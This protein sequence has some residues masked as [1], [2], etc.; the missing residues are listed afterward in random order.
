MKNLTWTC[1]ICGDERPDDKI[2][3]F[4]KSLEIPGVEAKQNVR[5][6]NDRQECIDGAQTF[7]FSKR[8]ER[9][10]D[11]D[12]PDVMTNGEAYGPAMKIT[13]KAEAKVYLQAL[14]DR[15]VR[16][17]DHDPT[18]AEM[19]VKTNLGY[20]SGYYDDETMIRVQNLFDCEHPVFGKAERG[21]PTPAE[22]FQM[23]VDL[24][25]KEEDEQPSKLG[26][27]YYCIREWLA[28]HWPKSLGGSG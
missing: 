10:L 2:S 9:G 26:K 24:A 15:H 17:T 4:S 8:G 21:L 20:Y 18:E 19:I 7:S 11:M 13:D 16:I 12:L 6:C 28:E 3:V 5:Y 25:T 22:A 23:G 14:I 1:H 27:I